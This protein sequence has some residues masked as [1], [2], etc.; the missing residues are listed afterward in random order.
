MLKLATKKDIP[1]IIN[2]IVP[3]F[4]NNQSVNRC[5]KQDRKRLLRIEN[6]IKYV[7]RLSIKNKMAFITDDKKGAVLCT[8]STGK[9]ASVFDDLYF[10]F[11]VS[12]IKLGLQLLKREKLLKQF[13]PQNQAYC[14]LWFIGVS[15]EIQGT[16]IGSKI[17]GEIKSLCKE[18][19]L[20]IYLETSNERN[21]AFYEKN[22]FTLYKKEQLVTDEFLL[23]FF[24][25]LMS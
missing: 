13:K 15:P 5:V 8:I 11:K 22:G 19:N 6:Q 1:N 14:H 9:K 25:S 4:N 12:G 20:P 2:T 21:I 23:Y 18:K 16:G 10:I 24:K 7:C 17:M 3:A